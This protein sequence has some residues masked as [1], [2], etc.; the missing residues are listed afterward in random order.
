MV[1][2]P[3]LE[4]CDRQSS[5]CGLVSWSS[6]PGYDELIMIPACSSKNNSLDRMRMLFT[7]DDLR[8]TIENLDEFA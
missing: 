1:R 8:S 2:S 5:P 3:I 6:T 4:L 7:D